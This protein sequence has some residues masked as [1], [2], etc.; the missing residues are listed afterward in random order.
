MLLNNRIIYTCWLLNRRRLLN[1]ID[2]NRGLIVETNYRT[3]TLIGLLPSFS[4]SL[5]SLRCT[6][7][8]LLIKS[9][10]LINWLWRQ[11]QYESAGVIKKMKDVIT[12]SMKLW[13]F[14][15]WS[16]MIASTSFHITHIFFFIQITRCQYSIKVTSTN[17]IRCCCR[18][19]LCKTRLIIK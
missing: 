6:H 19:R 16:Y 9:M 4:L 13:W 7:P 10:V 1:V 14:A 18:S 15:W 12:W 17:L 5:A 11:V 3:E 8:F 2:I